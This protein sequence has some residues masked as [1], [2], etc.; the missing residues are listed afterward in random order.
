MITNSNGSS[1]AIILYASA[2]GEP[3]WKRKIT[4]L[5]YPHLMRELEDY[6]AAKIFINLEQYVHGLMT[7]RCYE[8]GGLMP[9]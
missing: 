1:T 4:Y 9:T 2:I 5:I 7:G 6:I 8:N 3:R